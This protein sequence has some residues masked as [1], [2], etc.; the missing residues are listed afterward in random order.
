MRSATQLDWQ[1]RIPYFKRTHSWIFGH[2]DA[3]VP[4]WQ[5]PMHQALN[6]AA[7][8]NANSSVSA[9]LTALLAEFIAQVQQRVTDVINRGTAVKNLLRLIAAQ[10]SG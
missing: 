1:R 3:W 10:S 2:S 6:K 7:P 4:G 8:R 5:Q 9:E